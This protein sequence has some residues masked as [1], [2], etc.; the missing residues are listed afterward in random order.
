[1]STAFGRYNVGGGTKTSWVS[2]DPLFEL[3]N[4]ISDASR[5]NALTVYKNGDTK[6]NGKL[7]V[8]STDIEYIE[9]LDVDSGSS[10]VLFSYPSS[11]WTAIFVEYSVK[12]GTNVRA[13]LVVITHDGTNTSITD[14]VNTG[15][16]TTTGVTFSSDI[17][18]GNIRLLISTTTDNWIVKLTVRKI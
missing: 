2:S 10:V 11:T 16:G 4:G 9:N 1:M 5:S 14:N 18:S 3:G 6:V 7:S 12:N 15:L 8:K 13:G 17:S